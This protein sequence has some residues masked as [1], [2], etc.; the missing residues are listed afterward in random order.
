MKK[1]FLLVI[2]N[3]MFATMMGQSN[4]SPVRGFHIVKEVRPP[5]LDIVQGSVQFVDATGNN[6]IDANERCKIRMQVSNTG[7]G[8]AYG[9][10]AVIEA[11]GTRQGLNFENKKISLIKKDETQIVEF[12]IVAD[13]STVDRCG[14]IKCGY[15]QIRVAYA[16]GGRLYDNGCRTR[17]FG[18]KTS[19]RLAVAAAKHT[20]RYGRKCQSGD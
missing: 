6:A 17:R 3:L 20:I 1:T 13:M 18:K 2:A 14:E 4:V 19:V 11:S 5:V 15:T 12:P 9:C 10:T 16:E 8:D 7:M